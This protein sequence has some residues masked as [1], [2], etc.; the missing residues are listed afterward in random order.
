MGELIDVA[1]DICG[2]IYRWSD[3]RVGEIAACRECGT[4]FEVTEYTPP[5]DPDEAAMDNPLPWVKGGIVAAII[6]LALFG[7]GRLLFYRPGAATA[8]GSAAINPFCFIAF[9][10]QNGALN[11]STA[12]IL[13]AETGAKTTLKQQPR[14]EVRPRVLTFCPLPKPAI[15]P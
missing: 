14:T 4:K 12:S 3:E 11:T 7:L 6:V 9:V 8:G 2:Q 5:P 10:K 1:C 15:R 13:I